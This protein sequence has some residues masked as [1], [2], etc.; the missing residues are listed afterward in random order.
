MSMPAEQLSRG[1]KL[2][3]LLDGVA[4]APS[5]EIGGIT[6]D[7]RRVAPGDLFIACG[8]FERH[9]V[10]FIDTAIANGAA[11]IAYDATTA[12]A[13]PAGK[14]VPVIA[15]DRL[16]E[17]IGLIAN[18]WFDFPSHAVDVIGVTGTNGKTTVAWLVARCMEQV[19]IRCG[20]AGTL[21]YGV[22]DLED[23]DGLTTPDTIELHRRIAA[24]RDAGAAKA[25]IEVSSHALD[26]QRVDGLRFSTAMFTNLS[27][28]HLDYHGDMRRYGDAKA[29]LFTVH[30][31]AVSIINLDSEFGNELAGRCGG[32][33]ITVS[34]RF[35]RVAN[36]RPY[37]FARSVI[38]REDHSEIRFASAWGDGSFRFAMPGDFNVANAVI[39]LALLLR[40]GVAIDDACDALEAVTAPPGRMQRI[41]TGTGR[42][43]VYVDYAHTPGALE[44]ALRAL[45]P[46]CRGR[47]VCVF[48]CGGDRDRGKRPLMGRIVERLA[49]RVV[50]SNDNP[51]NEPPGSIIDEILGGMRKP[52]D[53]VVIEDRAAA[54][55][56][57][58]ET[59]ADDDFVLVAGKGHEDYQV[60]EDQRRRYSD[61]GVVAANL[62]ARAA[63]GLA[64]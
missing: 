36:G 59:A 34:T 40:D 19:G 16:R 28:D 52:D 23:T 27:R 58:I 50:V 57:S 44:A 38:A 45:K 12:P 49:D 6:V 47:L 62:E 51:R 35:N 29:T 60:I 61:A 20:Y 56:W 37:V 5:I 10:E 32:E 9:G 46:H 41:D 21:G 14:D 48:G 63:K 55:G 11:A 7:S 39:V 30:R 18:R 4:A 54:I 25:A 22:G 1:I 3:E 33:V 64:R 2:D 13:A 42:P 53:A 24:F 17:R 43:H 31:P 8:G 26:Q 15:V